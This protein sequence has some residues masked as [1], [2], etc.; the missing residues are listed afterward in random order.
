MVPSI[1]K[2]RTDSSVKNLNSLLGNKDHID[3]LGFKNDGYDYTQHLKEIGGGVFIGKNG[4]QISSSSLQGKIVDEKDLSLLNLPEDVFSS[5]VELQR[6][7]EAITISHELMDD[8]I[9]AALFDDVDENGEHFEELQDDFITHAMADNGEEDFDFDAHIAQLIARSENMIG[10]SPFKVAVGRSK[11]EAADSEDEEE[12]EEYFDEDGYEDEDDTGSGVVAPIS[13]GNRELIEKQFEKT[14][15]E[16]EDS[17]IGYLSEAES[18]ADGVIDLD[19]DDPLLE[20]ALEDF[21]RGQEE[22]AGLER[23]LLP[24]ALPGGKDTGAVDSEEEADDSR[25]VV[26]DFH[27]EYKQQQALQLDATDELLQ[28]RASSSA[29]DTTLEVCQEYLRE[30]KLESEWD[31]ETIISTYSVLEN[32]PTVIQDE[33]SA[34]GRRRV[35]GGGGARSS[36]S[37]SSGVESIASS[38]GRPKPLNRFDSNGLCEIC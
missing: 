10:K 24:A 19:G 7:L 32:H 35:R 3:P 9:R 28:A 15:L 38:G 34:A 27:V 14:Y 26:V 16:Y 13:Q 17:A 21:I 31:C 6:D 23:L 22:T 2:S 33:R 8:D 4:S 18:E 30:V 20:A 11:V 25:Q 1:N 37:Q 12:F 29:V 5:G 36:I